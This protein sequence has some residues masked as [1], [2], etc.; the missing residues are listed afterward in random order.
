MHIGVKRKFL[1]IT[2]TPK[3][4]MEGALVVEFNK[5]TGEGLEPFAYTNIEAGKR[6]YN[7]PPNLPEGVWIKSAFI[8]KLLSK[9]IEL[10][11]DA[12]S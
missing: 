11:K 2:P 10:K 4:D 7:L 12:S 8:R 9:K 5:P 6:K 3:K 1:Y